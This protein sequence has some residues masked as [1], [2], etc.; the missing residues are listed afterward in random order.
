M[1]MCVTKLVEFLIDTSSGG[2]QDFLCAGA[3]TQMVRTKEV[4]AT[5]KF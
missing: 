3:A 1:F 4:I 5:Q 2:P